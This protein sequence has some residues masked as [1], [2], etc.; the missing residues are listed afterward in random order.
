MFFIDIDN[1]IN[2][3]K[4]NIIIEYKLKGYKGNKRLIDFNGV[5]SEWF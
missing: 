2:F 5:F 1:K 3:I 4:K